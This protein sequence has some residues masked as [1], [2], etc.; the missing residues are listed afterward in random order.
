MSPCSASATTETDASPTIEGTGCVQTS[1][2]RSIPKITQMN[3][4]MI[5][6]IFRLPPE[7]RND[8][9][10][11]TFGQQACGVQGWDG[12]HDCPEIDLFSAC[13]AAPFPAAALLRSCRLLHHESK[14]IFHKMQNEFWSNSTFIIPL[15][16]MSPYSTSKACPEKLRNEHFD[17]ISRINIEVNRNWDTCV[18]LRSGPVWVVVRGSSAPSRVANPRTRTRAY[19]QRLL[20][21]GCLWPDRKHSLVK[22]SHTMGAPHA[23]PSERQT[24]RV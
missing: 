2:L 19:G 12:I 21:E 3:P 16:K 18:Y 4:Q 22:S 20:F 5:C 24:S 17:M 7:L 15:N 13:S 1:P 10:K 8:I 14:R 11:Y 23:L 9:Y 6:P